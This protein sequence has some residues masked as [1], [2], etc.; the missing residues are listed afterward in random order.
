[1]AY[2]IEAKGY[3]GYLIAIYLFDETALQIA[4]KEVDDQSRKSTSDNLSPDG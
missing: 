2:I 1:M 4:L 3:E